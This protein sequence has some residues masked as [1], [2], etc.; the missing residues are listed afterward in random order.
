MQAGT[1]QQ[2]LDGQA[3]RRG[4][5]KCKD[6]VTPRRS[7]TMSREQ[8]AHNEKAR[9][10]RRQVQK[11]AQVDFEP[12]LRLHWEAKGMPNGNLKQHLSKLYWANMKTTV[13]A[14]AEEAEVAQAADAMSVAEEQ[15]A[16]FQKKQAAPIK[17]TQD[18]M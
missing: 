12:E 5:A 18:D 6:G 15:V 16:A 4:G 10:K 2:E 9:I 17:G 1:E 3:V 14:A 7:P 8:G 11:K 13:A